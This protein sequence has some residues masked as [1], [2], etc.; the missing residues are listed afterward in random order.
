LQEIGESFMM[1][2]FMKLFYNRYS[3]G[4]RIQWRRCWGREKRAG[5]NY[6]GSVVCKGVPGPGMF[7]TVLSLS[8]ISF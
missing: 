1:R 4:E 3:S 2:S 8:V 7:H 6:R 5:K